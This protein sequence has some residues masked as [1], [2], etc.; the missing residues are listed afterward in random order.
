MRTT[1]PCLLLLL[2]ACSTPLETVIV[3]MS[4]K[5]LK[6]GHAADVRGRGTIVEY[7]PAD[8]EIG[9]WR[10]LVTVQFLEGER[11]SPEEM[12]RELEN[13]ARGYGGALEWRVLERDATS[14]VYEWRLL[15]CGKQGP[16]YQDQCEIA[17]LL[18][19]ND[20]LHRVA[21]TERARAMD[22]TA[23]D[24]Y[25]EAFRKAYVVKGPEKQ[26]VVVAPVAP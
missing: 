15:D 9:Q 8:E 19:G 23:R 7:I 22:A 4:S 11:R 1:A 17:R 13:K 14:L 24:A 25:L 16:E 5:G 6:V 20:G 26:R 12:V 21:Y 3:P 10:H 18:R 2:A